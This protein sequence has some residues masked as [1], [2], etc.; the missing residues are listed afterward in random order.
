MGKIIKVTGTEVTIANDDDYLKINPSELDFVPKVGDEVEVHKLEDEIIITK[1][2][3]KKDDKININIVNENNAVQNQSQVVNTSAAVGG[4]YVNKWIYIILAVFLGGFGAHHFYA[5]Y[6][7]RGI[8][9][10]IFCWTGI[11]TII[12]WFQA[13]GALFKTPNAEGK[14]LV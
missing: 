10:L 3:P 14:I 12:G 5:G 4:H 13:L 7:G 9:Y 6:S 8:K 11:P 1:I 2:E